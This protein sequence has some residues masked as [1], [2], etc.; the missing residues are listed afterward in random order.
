MSPTSGPLSL[1]ERRGML[2]RMADEGVELLVVG[3]GITGAGVARDAALRGMRVGLVEKS[4]FA[5]GTSSR[6]SKIIHGGVRYL[7][8]LQFGLVRESA[9]ERRI[10]R[11]IAPQLV[12]P[13]HFLFPVYRGESLLKIRAGLKLF[14]FLAGSPK[15]ERSRA[16]SADE[17]R[18]FLPGLRDPLKGAV[19]Y[20]EFIT[21]DARFTLANLVSALDHG[22]LAANH[23][24]VESLIVEEGRVVGAR[25][26]DTEEGREFTIRATVTVNATG[27]W[28]PELLAQSGLAVPQRIIPSR[29]SHILLPRA[30][31]PLEAATFLV[32]SSGRKGLAMPRGPWVYVGTTDEAYTGDVD[33]PRAE[34]REVDDLVAMVR[35]CFPEAGIG[36]DDVAT[37]WA[38]LRPLIHE[39][40]KATRDMSRH[41]E[42]WTTPPG[43]VTVA[44]GKLTTYR[45]MARRILQATVVA[46][47]RA[48]P[49]AES[50]DRIPLPWKPDGDYA[51]W[52]TDMGRRLEQIRIPPRTAERLLF[53]YGTALEELL[54]Y[55]AEDEEWLAPLAPGVPA[56]R[57][58]VRRAVEREMALTL[59][60]ILDRRLALLLFSEEGATAAAEVAAGIAAP[61]LGWGT[62]RVR[63]EI[64]D[65]RELAAEHGPRGI[66]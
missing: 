20:P 62:E 46:G 19:L 59:P 35:D 42:V 27:P 38:G 17:T 30:R 3:G 54:A 24:R 60:D 32:S 29:G 10:L 11:R 52:R 13:L 7:E 2:D 41:D 65:Y 61:L 49:G 44:G 6:S 66:G 53:L 37:T 5:A 21:D 23:A 14:D 45:P 15:N 4:D 33:H 16:I 43:L 31:L 47:G 63:A 40:G 18:A 56:L 51:T 50:T 55:G 58:E 8:Y 12:H 26:I 9:R 39:E 64:A 1:A 25:V 28:V 48:L 22:A 34:A 36:P 57:G